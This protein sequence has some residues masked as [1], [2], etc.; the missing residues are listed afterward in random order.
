M[1]FLRTVITSA[2]MLLGGF[3]LGALSVDAQTRI[4]GVVNQYAP[5]SDVVPCDSTVT[6]SAPMALFPGD[7][8]LLIQMKGAEISDADDPSYGTI[9]NIGGA[10]AAELLTVRQLQGNVVEFTTRFVHRYDPKGRIQ[11][12]R[13]PQY[14]DAIVD[15]PLVAQPWNGSTGG[16]LAIEVTG[17][18]YLQSNVSVSGMGFAGGTVSPPVSRCDVR[19][20]VI[21]WAFGLA[22]GKG[23]GIAS[24][25]PNQTPAGRGPLA[26]GG[27][28]GNGNNAGGAGGGNGGAGGAGGRANVYCV[29]LD[30]VGGIEGASLAS[31]A[32]DQ[33]FFMGGGGGGG[34]Q[35]DVQG[36]SG[37]PGGGIVLIRAG[38]V[39]GDGR[40]IEA[41]GASVVDTADMDAAGG[42]GAGGTIILD[43]GDV[44]TTINISARGGNGGH[45][46]HLYNA[47]GPGG[48][49]GGGMLITRMPFDKLTVNLSGGTPGIHLTKSNEAYQQT[50]GADTGRVGAILDTFTWKRPLSIQLDATGG[51]PICE[52]VSSATLEASPGFVSYLWNNGSTERTITV[53]EEGS[54]SVIAVDAIGCVR[55]VDGLRVWYNPTQFTMPTLVDFESIPI[56]TTKR[57]VLPIRN[58]DDEDIVVSGIEETESFRIISPPSFP[59][60]ISAGTTL[61]VVVEFYGREHRAY[62]EALRIHLSQ[63][64]PDSQDVLLKALVSPIYATFVVPRVKAEV[65]DTAFHLP[66]YVRLSPDTARLPNTHLR[67]TLELD[68][69]VFHPRRVTNGRIVRNMIDMLTNRRVLTVEIDSIDLSVQQPLV[70][71]VVGTVLMTTMNEVEIRPDFA[72][73]ISVWQ[74]PITSY[75]PGFLVVDPA[76]FQ[77]GRH[78]RIYAFPSLIIAPNPARDNIRIYTTLTA[79]GDYIVQIVNIEGSVLH[80]DRVTHSGT[81]ASSH[82]TTLDASAW[83]S[84]QYIVRFTTPLVVHTDRLVIQR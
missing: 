42:G 17:I 69:R 62:A 30:S 41:N 21:N 4:R 60:T 76:C 54:Y 9:R 71:E 50:R 3:C 56:N 10:G 31:Y 16:V 5:V 82:E 29:P 8:V 44:A 27:G 55:V 52:G 58:T 72:E 63:P 19:N 84:G 59:I 68:A 23:E 18:L 1:T 14:T 36:T 40:T 78:I 81:L 64:C 2:L 20:Y 47:H 57:M 67:I 12:V 53:T 80:E 79:P 48:G 75:E 11:L 15:A 24:G 65:G 66:V 35:N 83:P 49:G 61:G 37:A 26:N 46:K 22:G 38:L 45:V 7:R 43:V 33:R 39:Y 51:G 25:K 32:A 70:T 34:H 13:V 73:W 6:M 28:G 74:L 77:E